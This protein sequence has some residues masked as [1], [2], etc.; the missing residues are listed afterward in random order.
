MSTCRVL[1][2]RLLVALEPIGTTCSY[3]FGRV[4]AYNLY[5]RLDFFL[6]VV[7]HLQRIMFTCKKYQTKLNQIIKDTERVD[8]IYIFLCELDHNAMIF[9][10]SRFCDTQR[11]Y[12][13]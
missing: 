2:I 12:D 11:T 8:I 3:K 5:I 13:K 7:V 4:K 10:K 9:K 1:K 6:N